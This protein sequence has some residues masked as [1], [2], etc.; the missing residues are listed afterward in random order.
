MKTGVW[1]DSVSM[2]LDIPLESESPTSGEIG[3]TFMGVVGV[4]ASQGSTSDMNQT[5]WGA[6]MNDTPLKPLTYEE[7]AKL[8]QDTHVQR[9]SMK[10][11]LVEVGD[12]AEVVLP[13]P[14][15][16]LKCL[17]WADGDVVT[18]D[19]VG[20]DSHTAD[21]VIIYKD[22]TPQHDV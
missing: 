7:V 14:T 5:C 17:G 18:I 19:L 13:L 1:S 22:P 8:I 12:G 21:H 10:I 16:M 2:E 4:A 11:R 15:N 3:C 9:P 6:P 20:Y